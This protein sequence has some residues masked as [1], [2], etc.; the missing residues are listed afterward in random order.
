[1]TLTLKIESHFFAWHSGSW[2][3]T[4]IP[5]LVT[6][7][8]IQ[9]LSRVG[10]NMCNEHYSPLKTPQC[11][12]FCS[13]IIHHTQ[14]KKRSN[15]AAA[16]VRGCFFLFFYSLHFFYYYFFPLLYLLLMMWPKWNVHCFS[17][18]IF[19]C[20]CLHFQ[21]Y[22]QNGAQVSRLW[23]FCLFIWISCTLGPVL[24]IWNVVGCFT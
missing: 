4:T 13:K 18:Y 22:W 17:A 1:M 21:V 3:C 7:G 2:W 20:F 23:Q 5:G 9:T 11:F 10:T 16:M 6:K 8:C 15:I 24:H 19:I 14:C 12:P